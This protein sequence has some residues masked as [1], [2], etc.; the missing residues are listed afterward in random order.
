M[1]Y[2]EQEEKELNQ[3]LEK[4]K[5]KQ[6]TAVRQNYIDNAFERMNEIDRSVWEII[7]K[8]NSYKDVSWLVWE[9]ADRVIDK[10]YKLARKKTV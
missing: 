2:T 3:Q 5:K 9:Q 8:A 10:Y 4:W 6:L 7:A 1:K